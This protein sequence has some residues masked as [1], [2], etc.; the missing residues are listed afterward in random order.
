MRTY[1]FL[2][3]AI[4]HV[5]HIRLDIQNPAFAVLIRRFHDFDCIPNFIK[6]SQG[7]GI[8]LLQ[9]LPS[10][11]HSHSEVFKQCVL[12]DTSY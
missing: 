4:N 6:P 3:V 9:N 5:N 10:V 11:S 8:N 1:R 2:C 12:N 7:H